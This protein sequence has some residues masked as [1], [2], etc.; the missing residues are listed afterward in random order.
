MKHNIQ[1]QLIDNS[2]MRSIAIL[3]V[4][5]MTFVLEASAQEV[6]YVIYHDV[7]SGN[8]ITRHYVSISEDGNS[9]VDATIFS[10][11]CIWIAE[12]ELV[13]AQGG[14]GSKLS[15]D[16]ASGN[17]GNRKRMY[18]KAF[19][20][21]KYLCGPSESYE[22]SSTNGDPVNL[23]LRT[24]GTVTFWLIDKDYADIPVYYAFSRNHYVYFE[25]DSWKFSS[26]SGTGVRPDRAKIAKAGDLP[27][28]PVS[29]TWAVTDGTPTV[30]M[31]ADAECT[32]R[33]TT[34]GSTPTTSSTQYTGPVQTE[35][36]NTI[37]AIAV[38]GEKKSSVNEL[39]LLQNGTVEL[40]DYE[41]HNWTYYSGVDN[42]VDNNN[43]VN[44]Y[45]GY[46]YSPNPR[47]VKITYEGN[48][49]AVSINEPETKFIYYKTLECKTVGTGEQ[50]VETYPYT[51]ISNPFSKRPASKGFG[52]WKIISGG[53]YIKDYNNGATLP[54]DAEI[55]FEKL[56]Y[57]KVNCISAEIVLEATWVNSNISYA[58]GGDINYE[59]SGGTYETNFLILDGET[60]GTITA[61]SPCTIMMVE[62]DGSTDYRDNFIFTGTITPTENGNTKIEYTHWQ[63][64]S[65]INARG[66]NFT[67]GRGMKMG[68][69]ARP[70]YGTGSATVVDQILKVESGKFSSFTHYNAN[71]TSIT[72]QW[73]TLGCDYDRA[74]K[75]NNKLEFTGAFIV[76]ESKKLN[77]SS[78]G[79]MCRVYSLSGKFMT[80]NNVNNANLTDCYY[81]SVTSTDNP[82]H[83][84]LEIQGGEWVS[85]A[86]GRGETHDSKEP[87][88][89]FRMKGGHLKGCIYGAAEYRNAGGIRTYV[90]TGGTINGWVA[91]GANGTQ[92]TEGQ[93]Y[94]VSYV[95]VGGNTII[96][97]NS[98]SPVGSP[99]IINRA[100]GGNVFGAGCGFDATSES[101]QVTEGTNVVIAD[102]AYVERGVYGG[103]SYGY[104]TAT[105]NIYI[106]GGTIGGNIGGVNIDS[107]NN[108]SYSED[109]Q[110]G[111][112]GGACQN[113]GGNVNIYMTGGIV[114]GGIY[115]G[116]NAS[117]TLNAYAGVNIRI[118]GGIVGT[119]ST[120]A[121]VYGGGYGSGATVNGNVN[122]RMTGGLIHGNIFGG[123]NEA[124][125]KGDTS[126]TITGGEVKRNVYGGGNQAAVSGTTNVVI[127]Q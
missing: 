108:I 87:A 78:K 125:V 5:L 93:M 16:A 72:R 48:G 32:I 50:A 57:N 90:I 8:S 76:G 44:N 37:K 31:T 45:K 105:S 124:D 51:V 107:S 28:I 77:L 92:L 60:T 71:P 47:N 35:W 20:S 12:S 73:I 102:N 61:K 63:P 55:I 34:D 43:Y 86:G 36:N 98:D 15:G 13:T 38:K 41:D 115:G 67:I 97:S 21:K 111:V 10:D 9:V 56:L 112:F 27:L 24:S 49:G 7:V 109:I 89:T 19:T 110:G 62:P 81:M 65:A 122:L 18:S 85:I 52:G 100:V 54:L 104:T 3:A 120:E 94:G 25:E 116:S 126:V 106:T 53:E 95:Y 118:T 23:T 22:D 103:G 26:G 99:T 88:F 75:D 2:I 6:E 29:F 121:S 123:G 74:K 11:R 1:E 68:E 64:S 39:L 83:R 101:G 70:V 91:G 40:N 59:V 127:G 96:G 84:Y 117:G 58:K 119:D 82:G 79:E 113:R 17:N 114:N 42:S 66:R 14:W 30:S 4:L 69:T 80:G 46:I 33:Y